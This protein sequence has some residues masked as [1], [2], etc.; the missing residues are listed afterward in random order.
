[1]QPVNKILWPLVHSVVDASDV[2]ATSHEQCISW[3]FTKHAPAVFWAWLTNCTLITDKN[4]AYRTVAYPVYESCCADGDALMWW[5]VS[6]G[7]PSPTRCCNVHREQALVVLAGVHDVKQ[8][9]WQICT[10]YSTWL[11]MSVS[12]CFVLLLAV[13][14]TTV[15]WTVYGINS[16]RPMFP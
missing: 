6:A 5:T 4:S 10:D 3:L 8:V 11:V 16:I 7:E 9:P 15:R 2:T 1:M 12:C 13:T 14:Q